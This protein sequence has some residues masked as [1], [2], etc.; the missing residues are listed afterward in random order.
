MT[1][2]LTVVLLPFASLLYGA[3]LALRDGGMPVREWVRILLVIA[4]FL[5]LLIIF[6]DAA[7]VAVPAALGMT[8]VFHV[9]GFYA[10]R[11]F[12]TGVPVDAKDG[13]R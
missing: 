6:P 10:W 11:L 7:P 8:V 2:L 4:L 9:A 12:S 1:V 3:S 5:A 13:E